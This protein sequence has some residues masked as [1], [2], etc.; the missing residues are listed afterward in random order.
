MP[1][2]FISD[3]TREE[4][5]ELQTFQQVAEK[6]KIP[7]DEGRQFHPQFDG[8]LDELNVKRE[9]K[10]HTRK[11]SKCYCYLLLI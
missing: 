2:F 4:K 5:N 6:L 10:S 7:F 11:Y 3:F 1:N 9:S 8:F